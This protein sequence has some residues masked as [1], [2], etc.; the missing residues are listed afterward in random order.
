MSKH[1]WNDVNNV[2]QYLR[3]VFG[4][5]TYLLTRVCANLNGPAFCHNAQIDINKRSTV[6]ARINKKGAEFQTQPHI[7]IQGRIVIRPMLILKTNSSFQ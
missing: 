4:A 1:N 2:P 5:I 6:Q 3:A 7:G